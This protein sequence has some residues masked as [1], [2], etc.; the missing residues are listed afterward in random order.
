MKIYGK[1]VEVPERRI[2]VHKKGGMGKGIEHLRGRVRVPQR[3]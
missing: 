2:T 1:G 3:G